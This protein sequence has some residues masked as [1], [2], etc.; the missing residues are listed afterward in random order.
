V[1]LF[2]RAGKKGAPS[3]FFS[4]VSEFLCLF[5]KL[6]HL[7]S[8]ESGAKVLG[9]KLCGLKFAEVKVFGRKFVE[10]KCY[11]R[12]FAEVEFFSRKMCELS[13]WEKICE[14]EVFGEKI[15]EFFNIFNF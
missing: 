12:K 7:C 6:K 4:H 13:F 1:F 5:A 8:C 10:A 11:G 2:Q 9:G 15:T 14:I 3:V